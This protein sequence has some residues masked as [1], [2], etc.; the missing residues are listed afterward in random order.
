MPRSL[1]ASWK[2][3]PESLFPAASAS[4]PSTSRQRRK[5]SCSSIA[6]VLY[7]QNMRQYWQHT[8]RSLRVDFLK[9]RA[10]AIGYGFAGCYRLAQVFDLFTHRAAFRRLEAGE[11][12]FQRGRQG[13]ESVGGEFAQATV[14]RQ[15]KAV[16]GQE[17]QTAP[18]EQA[19]C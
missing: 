9:W 16:L 4:L 3:L 14:R 8:I 12:S 7:P 19:L 17:Q 13:A 2:L 11:G 15:P 5:R 6:T 18:T 1:P 10:I